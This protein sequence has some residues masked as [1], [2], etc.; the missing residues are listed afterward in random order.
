MVEL[1]LGLKVQ[2]GTPIAPVESSVLRHE[3]CYAHISIDYEF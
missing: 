2:F 1:H 3:V